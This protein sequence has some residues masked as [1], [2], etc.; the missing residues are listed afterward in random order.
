MCLSRFHR[1]PYSPSPHLAG[2]LSLASETGQPG[3]KMALYTTYKP[4]LSRT[5]K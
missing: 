2:Q 4:A 5:I 3:R 1:N